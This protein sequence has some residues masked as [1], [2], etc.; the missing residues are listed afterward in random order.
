MATI[1]LVGA[2]FTGIHEIIWE[3]DK[4]Y[5]TSAIG[6]MF[7]Y[8]MWAVWRDKWRTVDWIGEEMMTVGLVGTAVGIIIALA[9]VDPDI[10]G[11]HAAT[12]DTIISLISGLSTALYT[13]LVGAVGYLW[14]SLQ[15]H[16]FRDHKDEN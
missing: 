14:F 5:L 11:S 9:G 1:L 6:V 15:S 16:I 8:G 12:R 3:A 10:A 13:T 4:S 2:Y 7:I